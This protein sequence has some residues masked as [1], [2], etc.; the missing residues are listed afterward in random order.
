MEIKQLFDT[1]RKNL[2]LAWLEPTS[3][4]YYIEHADRFFRYTNLQFSD[5]ENLAAFREKYFLLAKR[6]IKNSSLGKYLKCIWKFGDFLEEYQIISK[7]ETRKQKLPRCGESPVETL[8]KTDITRVLNAIEEYWTTHWNSFWKNN[9]FL[10]ER[11]LML[12]KI[13]CC[14]GIRRSEAINLTLQDVTSTSIRISH[15]KM[16]TYRMVFIPSWLGS[17][18][19][20]YIENFQPKKFLFENFYTNE[21]L[22]P[23][24]V[25]RIIKKIQDQVGIDLYTHKFRHTYATNCI[26]NWIDL[27]T[28][29]KQLWHKNIR[30]TSRYLNIADPER[31]KIIQKISKADFL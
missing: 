11:N 23:R 12:V 9:D 13:L 25:N 4:K 6:G 21:K 19:S 10:E 17:E 31:E 15:A 2:V 3:I 7:N 30:T 27:H 14:T 28:L 18:I 26:K 22:Q 29:Q 20:R 16:K 5:F 1:Y 24:S 8:T